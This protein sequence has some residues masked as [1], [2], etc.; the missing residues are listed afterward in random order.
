MVPVSAGGNVTVCVL[1]IVL[2]GLVE[3]QSLY[4]TR[5][6]MYMAMPL[7]IIGKASI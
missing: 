7:G 3:A 5:S 4:R 6:A 1:M 2:L